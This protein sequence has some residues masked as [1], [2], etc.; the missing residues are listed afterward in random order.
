MNGHLIAIKVC[1]VRC[2][3][4]RMQLNSLAF[5]QDWFKRLDAEPMQSRRPIQQHRVF[6]YDDFFKNVPNLRYL[7]FDHALGPLDTGTLRIP[8]IQLTKDKGFEQFKRHALGQSA[9]MQLQGWSNHNDR[10]SRIVD[11]FSQ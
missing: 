9:L 4:Q 10:T 6:A 3:N 5:Y 7:F 1:V 11:A 8:S 2:A